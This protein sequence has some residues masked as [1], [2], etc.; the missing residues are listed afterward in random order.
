MPWPGHSRCGQRRFAMATADWLG[1]VTAWL[2]WW[3]G[4]AR[5]RSIAASLRLASC[6]RVSDLVRTCERALFRNRDLQSVVDR[7]ELRA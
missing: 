6:G 1:R 7:A 2:A 3:E 4:L 5:L